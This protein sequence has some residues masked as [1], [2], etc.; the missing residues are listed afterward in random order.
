MFLFTLGVRIKKVYVVP[1]VE[2][3]NSKSDLRARAIEKR[4]PLKILE[5]QPLRSKRLLSPIS[6]LNIIKVQIGAVFRVICKSEIARNAIAATVV[7][8]A[9]WWR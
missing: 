5:R 2:T 9:R 3:I 1:G 4:S 8:D 7:F 6:S